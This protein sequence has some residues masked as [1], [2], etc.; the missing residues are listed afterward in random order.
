MTHR[1]A[2]LTPVTRAELIGEVERGWPQAEVARQFRVSRATVAK[3]VRRCRRE[4]LSGLQDRTSRPRR[5]P[6]QTP[7]PVAERISELRTEIRRLGPVNEQAE[8]D[9][10]ESRERYDFLTG[11]ISDLQE[12]EASLLDAI[13]ELERIIKERFSATFQQVQREFQRYF[14]TFFGG[15]QAELVLTKPDERGL[16]GVDIMAQPPRKRV[17]SLHML[18]GGERSLTAVALLFALLHI[19]PSPICVLDEVDAA[20]D[21][22]N[23]GRFTNALREL[24][25]RTQFI[26]ITH[27]R[28]TIEMADTIYGVSMGED[29]V[30]SL[31]SLRL[32]DIPAK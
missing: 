21:E 12:A 13:Q 6:H 18:S 2:R 14:E 4:G 7:G 26:I 5:S 16:P 24:A 19:H 29:S 20:L 32:S 10:A 22:A 9:Y 27:N 28:R 23:V 1:N 31:L 17:R 15:G 11:Q 8:T 3:W 25:E 30:S